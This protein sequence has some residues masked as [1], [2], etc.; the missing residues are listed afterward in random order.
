MTTNHEQIS[1][2]YSRLTEAVS[3]SQRTERCLRLWSWFIR[4]RDGHICI[5]CGSDHRL[6]AHHICRKSFMLDARF[7]TGNGLT[8]CRRCHAEAHAGFNGRADLR[9]PMDA[10]GGEKIEL[11]AD[12]YALLFADASA[13]G[14]ISDD[15]YFLSDDVLGRFKMFQ[16]FDPSEPFPG[17]RLEQVYHIWRQCPQGMLEAV[18]QAN[19]FDAFEGPMMPGEVRF[20]LE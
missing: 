18:L 8:L 7:Q 1:L 5:K 4:T 13:R 19:G 16:G 12:L 15:Y 6:A 14:P 11:M 2:A 9:Q 17:G 20:V 3:T 10:Q